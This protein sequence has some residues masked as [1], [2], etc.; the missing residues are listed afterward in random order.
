MYAIRS[1]YERVSVL[2][3][4]MDDLGTWY[5]YSNVIKNGNFVDGTGWSTTNGSIIVNDV[6]TS[7]SIHYTKLYD[8]A[9]AP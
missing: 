2:E 1:Y 7:Y 5:Y 4:K 3:N 6:I 8:F 9:K